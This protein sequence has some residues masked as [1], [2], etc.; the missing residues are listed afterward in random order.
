MRGFVGCALYSRGGEV[1][2]GERGG[3]WGWMGVW[4]CVFTEAE[5]GVLEVGHAEE[6]ET[7]PR[8]EPPVF[9]CV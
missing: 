5:E 3:I 4:V 6:D 1:G 7:A 9:V 8:D 2:G